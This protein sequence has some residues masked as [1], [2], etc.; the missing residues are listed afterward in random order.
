MKSKLIH[1]NIL[2]S[3]EVGRLVK[4]VCR[5]HGISDATYYNWKAKYGGMEA[6]DIKRM[7]QLEEENAKLKRMFADLSLENRALKDVIE[8]KPL[9]PAEK[10]EMA[11]YLVQEH[12]LSL[13]RSCSVL[14]LSRTA[15]YY[16][17]AMDKDEAVIKELVTI[18]EHYPRYGFR[19]LF[20]KLRQA[21]FS[22]NHK[23]VY[24]VYCELKL[25]IRRK[26]KRRLAS[27]HPEPLAVPDSLNHTWSAD[28]MSDALN[29]G[30][31]FRTF[32]VVDDFNR[33]ALAIEIDLSLPALRV[34][35]VLDHIAANRGY[36]AR[37]RLD[38]GPEFISL[39]LADWAE[40]HG[41]ILEFIQPGK[42]TQNSFVERFNRTYRNE[43]L[44]FYLFRSLNEVR[45][46][47]TNWMKEYNEERPHESLGDMSPLDYRLIKN[48][49]ENSNYNWH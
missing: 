22:W 44:D 16:Q 38:N 25:N 40:K 19:K 35:R 47:T 23:R 46:I 43:I 18:T 1:L 5:E 24:R 2:K 7:K 3:V 10:R 21:G 29:C 31:R 28:F 6:S 45:D 20:I 12:G 9:K 33:E 41:V 26:G 39:A 27:R 34:I 32:N 15:Y 8:K 42:P 37:L 11:D 14:R 36:P 49:S 17:P 48:R 13:R 30:R 4:D